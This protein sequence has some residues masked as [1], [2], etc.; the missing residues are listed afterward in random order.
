MSDHIA[1]H[2]EEQAGHCDKMGSPFTAALCR[3]IYPVLNR[4][5]ATG[6]TVLDWPGDPRADALALRLCGGLH[7]LMLDGADDRLADCY[8]PNE[9]IERLG[10]IL[11]G[12]ISRHDAFISA[13]LGNAPQTN[14]I[15]RAAALY[16]GLHE[17][18]RLAPMPLAL[19]EIGASA[20]L[21]L[22]ADQFSYRFGDVE[23]GNAGSAV[24]LAPE[25]RGRSPERRAEFEIAQR[26]GCDIAPLDI[27]NPADRL[28]LRSY[29]WPDQPDRLQ[30]LDAAISIA[31]QTPFSLFASDAADYLEGALSARKL[32]QFFV[33]YHSVMWQYLPDATKDRV[34]GILESAGNGATRD[35][36]IAWL[37]MEGLGG[38][39]P[40][41]TLQL[42]IW[43]GGNTRKLARCDWHCRWIEWLPDG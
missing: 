33:L 35:A 4:S 13:G 17:I 11:T 12:V 7:A 20:G 41:A 15:A 22:M 26:S 21:N 39:E 30:R 34:E 3:L 10:Q 1:A 31:E 18:A 2:F 40:Y 25:M 28:R 23:M 27:T 6:R 14:E 19:H 32:G 16:P 38:V 29:V 24:Q 37:R 9:N 43:P 42:T 5:T 36:P 8:P